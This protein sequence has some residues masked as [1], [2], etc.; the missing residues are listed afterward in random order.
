MSGAG[1]APLVTII[2]A[3]Y[4]Q[5]E[6]VASA[7]ESALAQTY[8]R[9]EILVVD[10][11][12][13]DGTP[14]VLRQYAEDR[15]VRMLLHSDNAPPTKRLNEAI[16][17]SRGDY[18]SILYGDDLYLPEKTE[19]QIAEFARRGGDV[20]VVHSPGYRVN[21]VTGRRWLDRGSRVDGDALKTLVEGYLRPFINPIS[22]L[23][24]RECF[25]QYPFSEGIFAEA[26]GVY[27]RIAVSWRFAFLNEPLVVM[28]E[29]RRNLGK[30]YR[31]NAAM[32]LA[33]LDI[34]ASEVGFPSDL[35]PTIRKHKGAIM[36]NLAWQTLRLRA[37]RGEA[38]GQLRA[39]WAYDAGQILRPRFVAA[40]LMCLVP[41]RLL[42]VANA[43][44]NM[45]RRHPANRDVRDGVR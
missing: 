28:R 29:H 12:S 27:A 21:V 25:V 17:L 19:R 35:R 22:P 14:D 42:L 16:G 44:G 40:L 34:L 8:P 39:A 9:V 33:H 7:I 15:R 13:T 41:Q 36:T 45:L 26:E 3:T 10:N 11:G 18:I 5:A 4:Q 43:L 20:G 31:A 38:R 24:R 1:D 2:V 32:A 23:V 6:F 30:A 37:G